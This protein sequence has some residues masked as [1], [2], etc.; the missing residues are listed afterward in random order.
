MPTTATGVPVG[1]QTS[2]CTDLPR[3]VIRLASSV[4]VVDGSELSLPA[5]AR[6][7]LEELRTAATKHASLPVGPIDEKSDFPS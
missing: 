3:P 4:G 7:W 1:V 2:D 5:A 6:K